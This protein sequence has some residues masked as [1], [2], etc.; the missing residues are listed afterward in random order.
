MNNRIKGWIVAT[1]VVAIVGVPLCRGG[2]GRG[3]SGRTGGTGAD[4]FGR[5][6]RR[7]M[8][9]AKTLTVKAGGK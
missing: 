5:V 9:T 7:W 1:A 6:D 4:R 8:S 3:S 2:A